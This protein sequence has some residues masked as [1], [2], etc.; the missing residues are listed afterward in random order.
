VHTYEQGGSYLICLTVHKG[1][2]VDIY[3]TGVEI[4][5]AYFSN[6]DDQD[7]KQFSIY[8]NPAKS[9][10]FIDLNYDQSHAIEVNIFNTL[11][12]KVA[13][14]ISRQVSAGEQTISLPVVD[15]ENGIYLLGIKSEDKYFTQKI[16]ISK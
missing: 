15:L 16:I 9:E 2:Q 4:S 7:A 3:C 8:P 13:P 5:E 12:Q 6:I 1:D 11:M 10:I 14:T